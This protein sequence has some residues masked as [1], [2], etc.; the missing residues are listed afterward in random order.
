MQGRHLEPGKASVSARKPRRTSSRLGN[1]PRAVDRDLVLLL[2]LLQLQLVEL[3]SELTSERP[4]PACGRGSIDVG[5][6][7]DRR[8]MDGVH[9]DLLEWTQHARCTGV[10]LSGSRAIRASSKGHL[11]FGVLA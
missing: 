2:L 11:P 6:T 8:S 5:L 4:L 7:S 3:F 1:S 10:H 9:G